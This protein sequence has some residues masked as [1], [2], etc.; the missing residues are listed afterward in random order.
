MWGVEMEQPSLWTIEAVRVV[1]GVIAGL[2]SLYVGTIG[3][4][5]VAS[6]RTLNATMVEMRAEQRRHREQV[7]EE[8]GDHGERIAVIEGFQRGFDTAREFY[9]KT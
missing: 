6:L 5:M 1:Y 9:K 8:L 7:A 4:F 2:L 3:W